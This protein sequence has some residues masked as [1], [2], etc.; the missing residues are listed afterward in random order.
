MRQ[1]N[2]SQNKVTDDGVK[3]L[4][5]ALFEGDCALKRLNLSGNSSITQNGVQDLCRVL[6]K[7]NHLGL[8]G[9]KI[10]DDGVEHLSKTV[11]C[12]K[13]QSIQLDLSSSGITERGVTEMSGALSRHDNELVLKLHDN[14]LQDSDVEQLWSALFSK[15]PN[16][17]LEL[18]LSKNSLT[19]RS[20]SDLNKTLK[21]RK[22][23]T[24]KKRKN[25]NGCILRR[26]N[27]SHN[28]LTDASVSIF[29]ELRRQ[30]PECKLD[31][32]GNQISD[33]N[34]HKLTTS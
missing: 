29:E 12:G 18:D 6:H 11:G 5:D 32:T 15:K 7:L 10:G 20:V 4:S 26:L 13:C 9:I 31:L 21:N 27:F 28:S 23:E 3:Y 8:D 34:V 19:D 16:I 25:G 33:E 1:L 2:L 24:K 14:A 17:K 22:T 30:M